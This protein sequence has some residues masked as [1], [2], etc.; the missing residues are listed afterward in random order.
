[1]IVGEKAV[2]QEDNSRRI[3]YNSI[4]YYIV[5]KSVQENCCAATIISEDGMINIISAEINRDNFRL[6]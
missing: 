2:V 1:M 5:Q 4:H 6:L 3:R